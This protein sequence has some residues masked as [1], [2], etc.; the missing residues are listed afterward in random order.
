MVVL[1]FVACVAV[2]VDE[3]LAAV[4]AGEVFGLGDMEG[5]GGCF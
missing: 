5:E 1:E 2:F 3:F 4:T